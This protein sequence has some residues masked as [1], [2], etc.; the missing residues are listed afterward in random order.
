ME[1]P[2]Q[3]YLRSHIQKVSGSWTMVV[4]L[5]LHEKPR[6]QQR[7]NQQPNHQ[8]TKNDQLMWQ[9]CHWFISPTFVLAHTVRLTST[10][11]SVSEY[12]DFPFA[13]M[14]TIVGQV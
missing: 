10:G 4:S 3:S 1:L 12:R 8:P 7:R 9:V 14:E 5:L 13:P 2:N 11:N 6:N